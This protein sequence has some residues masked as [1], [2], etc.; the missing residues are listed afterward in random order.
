MGKA[1]PDTAHFYCRCENDH[2]DFKYCHIILMDQR[3]AVGQ[4]ESE[5][6]GWIA[7]GPAISTSPNQANKFAS[8]FPKYFTDVRYEFLNRDVVRN[9]NFAFS[10]SVPSEL[11]DTAEGWLDGITFSLQKE[12]AALFKHDT[13]LRPHVDLWDKRWMTSCFPELTEE[14]AALSKAGLLFYPHV[15]ILPHANNRL[16]AA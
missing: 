10:L 16:A 4:A 5:R 8:L 11:T 15:Q 12:W 1:I 3:H 6:A 2:P 7:R 13:G 14:R 9:D